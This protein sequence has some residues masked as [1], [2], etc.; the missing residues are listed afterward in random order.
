V[1]AATS[2]PAQQAAVEPRDQ[3]A[4]LAVGRERL[5]RTIHEL[6]ADLAT[7]RRD[8]REKQRKIDS[9]KAENARLLAGSSPQQGAM[10]KTQPRGE[11]P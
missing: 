5:A 3:R 9:L 6:V 11:V 2:K 8:C 7:S 10:I 1:S 4:P